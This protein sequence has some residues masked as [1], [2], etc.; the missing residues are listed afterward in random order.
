MYGGIIPMPA[1]AMVDDIMNVSLCDSVDGIQKNVKVD[2]FI[3]SKKLESQVGEGKCQWVHIGK[4]TC[5]SV[6]VCCK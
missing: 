3:K 2:E 6:Y 1:L 5:E 4:N